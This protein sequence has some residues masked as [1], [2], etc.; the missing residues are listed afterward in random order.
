MIKIVG[1]GDSTTAG[2]PGF[3]SPIEAPPNGEG[4]EESQYAFWLMKEHEDWK[5]LNRGVNGERTDQMLARFQRDVIAEGPRIVILLGGVNDIFQRLPAEFA[6][7][8]LSRM[9]FMARKAGVVPLACTVLPYDVI[10]R[11]EAATRRELNGWI[12]AESSGRGFPFCDTAAAVCDPADPDRLGESPDGLH[13]DVTGYRKM[14]VSISKALSA[15]IETDRTS[16]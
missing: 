2:T 15:Y 6:E 11:R 8:N 1:L 16:L 12:R 13:P 10:G 5:V 9:Y 4:N 3:L 14:A 7:R